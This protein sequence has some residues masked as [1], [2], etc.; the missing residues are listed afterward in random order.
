MT[1]ARI[2][3]IFA[4][5]RNGVI[6]RDNQLP[7]HLPEDM[8]FF[9]QKTAGGTVVMGRKTWD[10][11]PPRFRPLPGRDNV[12]VT[13]QSGW[14][15]SPVSERVHVAADL[16]QALSTAQAL[17]QPVWVIGGA[18]IYA[19][20][21]ALADEVWVTEI[22]Q[23]FDGDAHAPVL[24]DQWQEASRERHTSSNGLPFAFVCYQRQ[25]A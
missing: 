12:V 6:G 7:W 24:G 21:L 16:E 11:L 23:D 10:S 3:L 13:R 15:P 1:P 18:Q 20:S 4:R 25:P 8:A 22:D 2:H 9:K 14:Q 17:G 19:Q 5:A